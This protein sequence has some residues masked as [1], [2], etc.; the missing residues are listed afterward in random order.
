[1]FMTRWK[2]MTRRAILVQ[3][4]YLLCINLDYKNLGHNICTTILKNNMQATLDAI[5]G[6]KQSAV[7]NK[8]TILHT[9]STIRHVNCDVSHNLNKNLV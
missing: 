4:S 5:I 9:F 1:M 8:T 3:E 6:E 7:I 2:S